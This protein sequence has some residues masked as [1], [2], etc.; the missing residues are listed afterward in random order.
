MITVAKL[1]E[2]T[3]RNVYAI[4]GDYHIAITHGSKKDLKISCLYPQKDALGNTLPCRGGAIKPYVI[5]QQRR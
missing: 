4:L 1:L 2:F 5:Q 3:G